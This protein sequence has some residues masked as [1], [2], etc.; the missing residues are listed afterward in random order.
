M[1]PN[2]QQTFDNRCIALRHIA[3]LSP[4]GVSV[5]DIAALKNA[6]PRTAQRTLGQLKKWVY[7]TG[8]DRKPTGYKFNEEKREELGL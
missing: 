3:N 4:N 6:H 5:A 7:L 1:N 8:D 2:P